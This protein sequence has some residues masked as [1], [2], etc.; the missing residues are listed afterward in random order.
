[1]TLP[2]LS[3]LTPA[4]MSSALLLRALELSVSVFD[5]RGHLLFE[6]HEPGRNFGIFAGDNLG[7]ED[8]GVG[9]AALPVA[10]GA[11]GMA[12]GLCTRPERGTKTL[13]AGKAIRKANNGKVGMAED[14]ASQMPAGSGA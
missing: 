8:A 5:T 6:F 10:H 13:R 3:A 12:G 2:R 7:G 4:A 14:G 11:A 9:G 1:M